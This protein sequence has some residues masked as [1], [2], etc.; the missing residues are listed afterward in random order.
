MNPRLPLTTAPKP[1]GFGSPQLDPSEAG[2]SL[3]ELA[4]STAIAAIVL[5]ASLLI[6]DVNS[7]VSRVQTQV[8]DLQQSQRIAQQEMLRMARMA[9]RG[10]L[11]QGFSISVNDS[12][13]AGFQVAGN[14]VVPG[15]DVLT[16][17]GVFSAPIFHVASVGGAFSHN[18][19]LQT[20]SLAV[21]SISPAGIP[22]SLDAFKDALAANRPEGLLIVSP[23]DPTIYAVVQITGGAVVGADVNGDGSVDAGEERAT[24]TF[25]SNPGSSAHNAAYIGMSAGG[26]FSPRLNTAAFVGVLEEYRFYI[27]DARTAEGG[28][29]PKLSRA[30][31]FPNTNLVYDGNAANGAVDIADHVLDLQVALAI[32][33]NG[34]RAIDDVSAPEADEWL[35][36]HSDDVD[37]DS[38]W[39]AADV[40]ANWTGRLFQLRLT[41]L[42]RTDRP[43]PGYQSDPIDFLEN[44]EYAEPDAAANG[45]QVL[46]RSFRRRMMATLVDLRNIG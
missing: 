11:P 23:A 6:F 10:G 40:D 21:D 9:G 7:R 39:G 41:T 44:H 4:V 34:D 32:D 18:Q 2:F 37:T 16:I 20:G 26:A 3:A 24:L 14:D 42:V 28:N 45:D 12:V 29:E 8:T 17:R 30:Q 43:D 5:L 25:T 19:G 46:D 15:T 22:Q 13:P 35:F 36:N 31:V 38:F 1:S 27:R 33:V